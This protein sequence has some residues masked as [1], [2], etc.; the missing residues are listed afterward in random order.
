MSTVIFIYMKNKYKIKI[1][2]IND[3]IGDLQNKY[4][5]L[6]NKDVKELYFLYNGK[7]LPKTKKIFE[8]NKNEI[9]IFVYDKNEKKIVKRN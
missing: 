8:I 2:S 4:S 7:N 5:S 3:T 6:L 1:K 9:N